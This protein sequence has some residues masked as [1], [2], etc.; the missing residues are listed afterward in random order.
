M[1]WKQDQPRAEIKVFS[2]CPP[3]H[4]THR[5]QNKA[6]FKRFSVLLKSSCPGSTFSY[7]ILPL[8]GISACKDELKYALGVNCSSPFLHLPACISWMLH[9]TGEHGWEQAVLAARGRLWCNSELNGFGIL[10]N[11][12]VGSCSMSR[13]QALPLLIIMQADGPVTAR[14][15]DAG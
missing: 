15:C 14:G 8:L 2:G 12:A 7:C 9:A 3:L 5:L 10:G 4:S 6:P 13:T 11:T 1:S